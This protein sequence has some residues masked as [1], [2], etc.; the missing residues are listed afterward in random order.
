MVDR[1]AMAHQ[2]AMQPLK[3][4]LFRQNFRGIR[5][6]YRELS[7]QVRLQFR[8]AGGKKMLARRVLDMIGPQWA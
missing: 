7:D 8:A 6:R 4:P 2:E 1:K 3:D 5:W